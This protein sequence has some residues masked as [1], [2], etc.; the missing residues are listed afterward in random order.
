MLVPQRLSLLSGENLHD[1]CHILHQLAGRSLCSAG[2][3]ERG[4]EILRF[5][6][7]SDSF[8]RPDALSRGTISPGS[9]VGSELGRKR[10]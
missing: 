5:H 2:Q 6:L 10:P 1:V 9:Y 4:V 7:S 8:Y 3:L